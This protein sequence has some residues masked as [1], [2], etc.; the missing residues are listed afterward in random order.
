MQSVNPTTEQVLGRFPTYSPDRVNRALD[1]SRQA[2]QLWRRTSFQERTALFQSVASHLRANRSRIAGLITAEMGKVVTEAE[3]EIEKCA[4]NCEYYADNAEGFLADQP[5]PTAAAESYV[6]FEPIGPVL[7]IMPWN[8]PFWQLFRFAAPAL[9]AGNTALLKH[10][11]N[12]PQCALAI[13]EVF[14]A[15]GFPE[16]VLQTLLISGSTAEELIPDP[17]IAAVTLTGSADA[18]RQVGST[19]SSVLKKSVLELG[20]SD[21]FIVLED[22][23]LDQ[24]A[25]AAARSRYANVGQT[26]TAAKRFIVVETVADAFL[27]RFVAVVK[28]LKVGDP[29]DRSTQV[30]PMA[31]PDLRDTIDRQVRVF[32]SSGA[33]VVLGGHRMNGKGYFYEPTILTDVRPDM[34]VYRE[35]VFGPVAAVIRARDAEEAIALGNNTPYGLG[36]AI[37]TANLER[38]KTLARRIEAGYVAINGMVSSDPHLPFGGV[39]GSGY[40]RELSEYG[41]REFTNIQSIWVGPP[42]VPTPGIHE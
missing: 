19:A 33:K 24:A 39:K 1:A 6:S 14:S 13:E 15:S 38:A 7:A 31:R 20:G 9:M 23:D 40:G 36:A 42:V 5:H 35:E 17:R 29:T 25:Q 37:W 27:D 22:A 8:F 2:F 10:A 11:S 26:C 41:I 4:W 21:P 12:V 28:A 3:S 32:V 18:G 16:G 30:G 34:P